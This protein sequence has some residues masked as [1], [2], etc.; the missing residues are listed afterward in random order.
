MI[1][2]PKIQK[3]HTQ[4]EADAMFKRL[5]NKAD[6]WPGGN[7]FYFRLSAPKGVNLSVLKRAIEIE[8][9]LPYSNDSRMGLVS[10]ALK[11]FA[12]RLGVKK[13]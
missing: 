2:Q 13:L 7:I 11:C 6:Y 4:Q 8:F 5:W 9:N 12:K 3:F 1:H 10:T